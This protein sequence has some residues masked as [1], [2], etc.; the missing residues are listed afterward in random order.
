MA[1]V[2]YRPIERYTEEEQVVER[3]WAKVDKRSPAECW[4]WTAS[5]F[6]NGYGHFHAHKGIGMGAHRF[7]FAIANG[8]IEKGLVVD[9]I[10]NRPDCVNPDHLQAI[11]QRENVLRGSGLSA[12]NATKS[13]CKMGHPFDEKNTYRFAGKREC[14][15]CRSAAAKRC[16]Q[17]KVTLG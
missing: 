3:F 10:C 8:E 13:A 6:P 4:P 2:R 16:R 17:R 14:R 12:M 11:S 1:D 15:M 7:S 5:K 9:H